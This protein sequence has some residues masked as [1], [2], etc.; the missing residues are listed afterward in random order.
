MHRWTQSQTDGED[1][2]ERSW[3]RYCDFLLKWPFFKSYFLLKKRPFQSKYAVFHPHPPEALVENTTGMW[4]F[5]LASLTVCTEARVNCGETRALERSSQEIA[6]EYHNLISAS[7]ESGVA[8]AQVSFQWKNV[9]FL[10]L[11]VDFLLR[12]PDFLLKMLIL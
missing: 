5:P 3:M 9:D 12:N 1:R 11:N 7:G 2:L 4:D 8:V 10:L 6:R